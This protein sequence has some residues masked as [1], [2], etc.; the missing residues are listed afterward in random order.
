[1]KDKGLEKEEEEAER[2]VA[3]SVVQE[4]KGREG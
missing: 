2:E 4:G 1:M 3:S